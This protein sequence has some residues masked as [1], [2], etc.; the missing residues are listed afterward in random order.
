MSNPDQFPAD[1]FAQFLV[2]YYSGL[3]IQDMNL[4]SYD[5]IVK[6]EHYADGTYDTFPIHLSKLD[7]ILA[8]MK[9]LKPDSG[10]IP[11]IDHAAKM[12]RDLDLL[13]SEATQFNRNH[14]IQAGCG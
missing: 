9:T 14:S 1:L 3:R 7:K 6:G 10:D 11:A 8:E 5:V 12:T 2:S 13:I 4:S